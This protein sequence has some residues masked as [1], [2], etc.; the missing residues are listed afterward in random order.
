ML[1]RYA[2]FL[3][4]PD[5]V[6]GVRTTCRAVKQYF[7]G[8]PHCLRRH[9]HRLPLTEMPMLQLTLKGARRCNSALSA[10]RAPITPDMLLRLMRNLRGLV[11]ERDGRGGH[12][13]LLLCD[14]SQELCVRGLL[15]YH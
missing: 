4:R 1:K 8:V 3:V 7:K 11:H 14:T 2:A 12:A 10:P 9:G 13:G 15:N 6:T 5:P